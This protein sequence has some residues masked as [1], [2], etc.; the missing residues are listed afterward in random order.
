MAYTKSCKIDQGDKKKTSK[1]YIGTFS[2]YKIINLI[3]SK[4]KRRKRPS[5]YQRPEI[6]QR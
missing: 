6:L 2:Q 4:S 3:K 1:G 5:P